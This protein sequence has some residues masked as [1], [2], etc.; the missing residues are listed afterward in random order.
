LKKETDSSIV[1]VAAG[2]ACTGQIFDVK[3]Y[4]I[5]DGPGIRMTVFL[6]GCPLSCAWCHNPE[7]VSPRVQKLF[8]ASKCLGCRTCVEACT[9]DAIALA[10]DGIVT[11]AELCELCGECAEVCPSQ[12]TEM[13]GEW[14]TVD[15]LM[16]QIDREV[17][18]FDQSGGGITVS[19][20]EP[21]MQPEF[22]TELLDACGKRGIHRTLDTS[23]FAKQKVLLDVTRR[24][25]YFLYDLKMMDSARHKEHCGTSNEVIL[26]NL[27]A[28]AET[29]ASINIRVP[30]LVGVNDDDE[31]IVQT[32]E[33]VAGLAGEKKQVNLLLYHNIAK[34]KYEK[35]G[36]VFDEGEM[37]EPSPE[38][39]ERIAAIFDSY[40]LPVVVGG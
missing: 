29:G 11:D 1:E 21:L 35:L 7:S 12:A 40:G 14:V 38:S 32:A 10:D 5:N 8:S 4:A 37:G 6:K 39:V 30:L 26:E 28:L 36:Q 24:T 33:F 9:R 25:D 17:I 27:I 16:K 3:R 20:G 34:K 13:S 15:A 2:A 31:N 18:F 23:G 22:L 19:G